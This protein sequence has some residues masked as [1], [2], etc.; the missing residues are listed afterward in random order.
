MKCKVATT[1]TANMKLPWLRGEDVLP[2]PAIQESDEEYWK[3]A[4]TDS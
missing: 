4:R 2:A 1:S 3:R